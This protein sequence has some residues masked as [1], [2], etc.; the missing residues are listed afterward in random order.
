MKRQLTIYA[1]LCISIVTA[2][3]YTDAP[4]FPPKMDEETINQIQLMYGMVDRAPEFKPAKSPVTGAFGFTLG[5]VFDAALP[6]WEAKQVDDSGFICYTV[7]PDKPIK[8]FSDYAIWVT[9]ENHEIIMIMATQ[10][11]ENGD[12][13]SLAHKTVAAA[14]VKKYGDA[15]VPHTP[16]FINAKKM[17][18]HSREGHRGHSIMYIDLEMK[19]E[20][21]VE[22][23]LEEIDLDAL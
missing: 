8:Q 7:K 12:A 2:S 14:L 18:M 20:T 16:F 5:E 6:K 4:D 3:A 11:Y 22:I 9:K 1:L 13:L 10:K 23:E 19:V 21:R 17:V 15:L